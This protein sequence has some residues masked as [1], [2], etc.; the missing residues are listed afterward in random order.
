MRHRIRTSIDDE[1]GILRADVEKTSTYHGTGVGLW[2]IQW[3]VDS[4]GGKLSV[5]ENSPQGNVATVVLPRMP[6]P[7]VSSPTVFTG[8]VSRIY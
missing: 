4:L 3:C 5:A 8:V 7:N 1:I 2:V 6:G